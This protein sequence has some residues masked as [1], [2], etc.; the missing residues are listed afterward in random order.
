MRISRRTQRTSEMF[1]ERAALPE[2]VMTLFSLLF[3]WKQKFAFKIVCGVKSKIKGIF[4]KK[5]SN[6]LISIKK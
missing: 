6:S 2:E 5:Y 3:A 4:R 1:S